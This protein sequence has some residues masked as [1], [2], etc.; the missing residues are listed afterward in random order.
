MALPHIGATLGARDLFRP[1]ISK[2]QIA[3]I[4]EIGIIQP[5]FHKIEIKH[6]SRWV[7][8][9]GVTD[10]KTNQKFIRV[11]LRPAAG[12][13]AVAAGVYH[14]AAVDA[15][16]RVMIS[17][18]FSEKI[19]QSDRKHIR[20]KHFFEILSLLPQKHVLHEMA[21]GLQLPESV[22]E[23]QWIYIAPD[24]EKVGDLAR[25]LDNLFA[26]FGKPTVTHMRGYGDRLT[27]ASVQF[28]RALA[29]Y[30]H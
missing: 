14:F 4:R 16:R 1:S 3:T 23:N 2:P 17:Y 19:H 29:R 8:D 26:P 24:G 7:E 22:N 30:T 15:G 6:A 21:I 20:A 10:A 5:P 27:P 11:T 25:L 18:R 12:E 9:L 28:Q 13:Y